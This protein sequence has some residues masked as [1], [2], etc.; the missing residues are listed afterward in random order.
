M[1]QK[2]LSKS[3]I[4]EINEQ[5]KKFGIEIDKKDKAVLVEAE[6]RIIL[7]NEVPTMFYYDERIVPIIRAIKNTSDF[8][9]KAVV[10]MPAV[11][12]MVSG[13]DVMRPGIKEMTE[14][15]KDDL[16]LIVDQN[17]KKPLCIGIAL[18]DS[19]EIGRM[20]KGRVIKNIHYVGDRIWNFS[21]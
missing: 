18:Y 3:D 4:K 11:K 15:K 1:K 7:V 5:S 17:N 20:E 13:A 21:L 2:Q 14:F 12:F 6:T 19:S 10:D 9:N 16:V 8:P